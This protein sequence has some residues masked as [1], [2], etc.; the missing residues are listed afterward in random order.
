MKS[1][2]IDVNGKAVLVN[3]ELVANPTG[4]LAVKITAT[5]DGISHETTH[6]FAGVHGS[7]KPLAADHVQR[8]LDTARLKAAQ[9]VAM[10]HELQSQFA[11]VE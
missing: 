6:T 4:I 1:K 2:T 10:K 8:N 9:L 7:K 3:A 11:Q 5:F